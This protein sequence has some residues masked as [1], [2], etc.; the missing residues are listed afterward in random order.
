MND[1]PVALEDIIIVQEKVLPK[2]EYKLKAGKKVKVY[3]EGNIKVNWNLC[4]SCMSCFE[5]CPH[6]KIDKN[7]D[8]FN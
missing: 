2:L 7:F 6:L 1:N 4:V 5:A 3:V 8:D